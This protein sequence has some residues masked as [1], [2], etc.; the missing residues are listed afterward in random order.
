MLFVGL[1]DAIWPAFSPQ[2]QK[3]KKKRAALPARR[4]IQ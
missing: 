4:N 3:K 1:L 2:E